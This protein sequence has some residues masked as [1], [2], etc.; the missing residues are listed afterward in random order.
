MQVIAPGSRVVL[1]AEAFDSDGAITKVS[2]R[3]NGSLLSSVASAPYEYVWNKASAGTYDLTAEATDDRGGKRVSPSVRVIVGEPPNRPT[4]L[5]Y[6]EADHLGTPRQA[7]DDTGR[8][9]W[10]WMP[11]EPFGSDEA[12]TDPDGDGT[13]FD[14]NLRFPGQYLDRETGLH[15]NYFRDYDPSAGDRKSVV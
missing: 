1:R 6:V 13:P 3:R 9:V 8:L 10:R 4:R 11:G 15:Y 2:F 14:F 12:E 7:R 5:Y